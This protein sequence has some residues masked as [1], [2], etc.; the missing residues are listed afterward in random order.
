[1]TKKHFVELERI[2]RDTHPRPPVDTDS[3]Y[4]IAFLNGQQRQWEL[5]K[6][7]LSEFCRDFGS[8][9]FDSDKFNFAINRED[10]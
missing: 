9:R 2:L 8:S 7:E 5:L 4:V 1:M 10:K 6:M 3:E